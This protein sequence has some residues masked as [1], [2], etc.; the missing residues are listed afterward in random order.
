MARRSLL[1]ALALALVAVLAAGAAS[2]AGQLN[3]PVTLSLSGWVSSPAETAS[4]ENAIAA[5]EASHPTI[6]VDYRPLDTYQPDMESRFAAGNPPDVFY[7]D[8]SVAPDWI[9]KGYL[10]PLQGFVT[11]S[12]FDTTHFFPVLRRAFE[13]PGRK[14]YGF[15]KDWSP[16]AMF[17][18]NT[19]LARAGISAPTTWSELRQAAVLLRA[20]TGITPICLSADWA[21]LLAFVEQNGGSFLND[22]RN[23]VLINSDAARQA[24]DFYVGLVRDGLAALPETLGSGWCGAA[25]AEGKV[26]FAFEGTW[27]LPVLDA[28]APRPDYSARPMPANVGRGN[29]AFTVA[30]S[31]AAASQHKQAAWELISYLTGRDGMRVW[32]SGGVAL[33]A[34]DDVA[35]LPGREAFIGEAPI[36]TVWSFAPG[37][38]DVLNFANGELSSVFAGTQ[39]TSGMLAAIEAAANA[40]LAAGGG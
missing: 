38:S 16:L 36:S 31:M 1:C 8:S 12:G 28:A 24:A 3:Q 5:F 32:I 21:R 26:A 2:A 34:R 23:T 25:F 15:P 33:P 10:Q 27:L 17:T 30:Y 29:V 18:N 11:S 20:A 35:P 37:F 39:T 40:A 14:P 9:A 13:G 4:L 22:A 6:D 7:V 19:L